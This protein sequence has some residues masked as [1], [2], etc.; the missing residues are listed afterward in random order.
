MSVRPPTMTNVTTTT[1]ENVYSYHPFDVLLAYALVISF[2]LLANILGIF[3]YI[4]NNASHENSFSSIVCT[5]Y[6][7]HISGLKAHEK[8]GELPL[9]P[10]VARRKLQ[11]YMR[12]NAGGGGYGF[13]LA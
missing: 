5:T 8:L 13:H 7:I 2:A 10:K 11:W 1:P 4:S 3:A 6:G 12:D 9:D